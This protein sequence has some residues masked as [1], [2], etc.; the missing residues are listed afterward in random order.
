MAGR[1]RAA[2]VPPAWWHLPPHRAAGSK[3]IP[4]PCGKIR[5]FQAAELRWTRRILLRD[6][7]DKAPVQP[8][9]A[10]GDAVS[11]GPEAERL[12]VSSVPSAALL[13]GFIERAMKIRHL[14]RH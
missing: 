5:G 13:G 10:L 4:R 9:R 2:F 8:V 12:T 14:D 7:T 6:T 11:Y 1:D 3:N